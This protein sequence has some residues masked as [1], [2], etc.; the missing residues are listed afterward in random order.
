MAYKTYTTDAMVCGS[1]MRNTSDRVIWL[2]TREAGMVVATAKSIREERSKLR[3]ALQDFSR[4][5]VTFVRGKHD[6]RIVG[7][8]ATNNM[9]YRTDDR[10][11]RGMMMRTVRLLRRLLHGEEPHA[12]LF[13]MVSE[14]FESFDEE[15]TDTELFEAILTLRIL[16]LLGYVAPK[17][18]YEA[19]L[20]ASAMTEALEAAHDIKA[21]AHI[22]G[23]I[24]HALQV[25]HL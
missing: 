4:A 17:K 14:A 25:S 13:D 1:R 6:W 21:T 20:R 23:A 5:Q 3:F 8:E 15:T 19:V 24:K 18:E 9:Y 7:A 11:V 10:G 2:F 16:H 12:D 22:E